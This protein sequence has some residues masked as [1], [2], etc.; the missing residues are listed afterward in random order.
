MSDDW[1]FAPPPFKPDAALL[2]LRRS[3]RELGLAERADGCELRG[4]RVIEW[5][6]DDAAIRAR[7][8]R[9]PALTPQWDA[10][11]LKSAADQRKLVDEVKKRLERWQRED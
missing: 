5:S 4:K 3:L 7:L 2:Q 11:P 8:A 10:W 1:G 6:L 9:Q